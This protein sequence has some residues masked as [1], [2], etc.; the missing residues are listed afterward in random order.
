M[1][2][3]RLLA[4]RYFEKPA[5]SGAWQA[6]MQGVHSCGKNC[7]FLGY[8]GDLMFTVD[9][10]DRWGDRTEGERSLLSF[11]PPAE[12]E[13]T[14]L[15]MFTIVILFVLALAAGVGVWCLFVACRNA[16][17]TWLAQRYGSRSLH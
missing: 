16:T 8:F 1:Q 3:D 2:A 7:I 4:S 15:G 6:P 11:D 14:P 12:A 9:T 17:C 13:L 5:C 10:Y